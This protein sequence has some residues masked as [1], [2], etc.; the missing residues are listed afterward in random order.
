MRFD[1]SA[2]WQHLEHVREIRGVM[3]SEMAEESGVSK[4]LLTR[5]SLG[6]PVTVESLVRLLAWSGL[7]FDNYIIHEEDLDAQSD[8]IDA[9]THSAV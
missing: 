8:P 4:S 3:L 1:W 6:R 9:K 5:L 7:F 2:F